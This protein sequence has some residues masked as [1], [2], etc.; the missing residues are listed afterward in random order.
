MFLVR[1]KR[2]FNNC[3]SKE[4]VEHNYDM[5]DRTLREQLWVHEHRPSSARDMADFAELYQMAHKNA[6]KF[7]NPIF[8]IVSQIGFRLK[9]ARMIRWNNGLVFFDTER[10]IWHL[11]VR[12][13]QRINKPLVSLGNVPYRSKFIQN[14]E[15]KLDMLVGRVEN[16]ETEMELQKSASMSGPDS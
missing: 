7:D 5:Y 11:S 3:C 6:H 14:G 10:G 12:Q 15:D 8:S 16:E 13:T 2:Y 4:N 9:I 1:K